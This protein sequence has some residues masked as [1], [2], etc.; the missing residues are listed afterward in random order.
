[1]VFSPTTCLRFLWLAGGCSASSVTREEVASAAHSSQRAKHLSTSA[2]LFREQFSRLSIL[3][4]IE[5]IRITF[6]LHFEG[7][8]SLEPRVLLN[9]PAPTHHHDQTCYEPFHLRGRSFSSSFFFY[10]LYNHI[11]P[12]CSIRIKTVIMVFEYV[13]F[14][15]TDVRFLI[16]TNTRY[17]FI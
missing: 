8:S 4:W 12:S 16:I 7:S 13:T 1:M 5:I 6:I 9:L 3:S 14:C 10:H 11:V 15:H 17:S 2:T